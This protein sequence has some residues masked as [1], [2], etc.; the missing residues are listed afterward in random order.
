MFKFTNSLHDEYTAELSDESWVK[1]THLPTGR[2]LI[3]YLS[4]EEFKYS[5]EKWR[6]GTLIQNALPMLSADR[7]EFLMTG[8]MP[9]AWDALFTRPVHAEMDD[10]NPEDGEE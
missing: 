7:R 2:H 4:L 3:Y 8:I 5:V 9:D 1:V 6:M 10:A